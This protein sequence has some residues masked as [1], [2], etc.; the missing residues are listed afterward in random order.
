MAK[1]LPGFKG[2]GGTAKQVL[3]EKTGEILSRRKYAEQVKRGGLLTNE[4]LAKIN[5]QQNAIESISRPAKGRKSIQK[6]S[7]EFKKTVAE[8]R[9][10]TEAEKKR[11]IAKAKAEK[12]ASDKIERLNKR[13]NVKVPKF[14]K[15]LLKAG[16]KARRLGFNNYAELMTLLK[17]AKASGAVFSYSLGVVGISTRDALNPHLEAPAV[18]EAM[19]IGS[20]IDEKTFHEEMSAYVE[21]KKSYFHLLHYYVQLSFTKKY[22]EQRA[23]DAG[24]KRNSEGQW[25]KP[26]NKRKGKKRGK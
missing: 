19:H 22:Y 6:L 18:I 26:T 25:K 17:D 11:N 13:Q 9:L 7:P 4:E 20:V 16:S 21:S 1:L 14:K 10:E 12:K 8:V 5:R 24:Y 15:S 2:L 23:K 3:N